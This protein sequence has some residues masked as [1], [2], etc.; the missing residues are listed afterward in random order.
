MNYL[1]TNQSFAKDNF[2]NISLNKEEICKDVFVYHSMIHNSELVYKALQETQNNEI[3][4]YLFSDWV[5][6]GTY[7]ITSY[8]NVSSFE[9]TVGSELLNI[10]YS[11]LEKNIDEHYAEIYKKLLVQFSLASI[12]TE[13]SQLVISDYISNVDFLLPQEMYFTRI[14]LCEYHINPLNEGDLLEMPYHTDY[15]AS[16]HFLSC[17]KF[18]VTC[19]TYFN[20]DY[21]GGEISFYIDGEIIDYKPKAGDMIVFPSGDPHFLNG[22]SYL[23]GVKKITKGKKNICRYYLKYKDNKYKDNLNDILNGNNKEKFQYYKLIREKYGS[24]KYEELLSHKNKL[25][26]NFDFEKYYQNNTF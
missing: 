10:M 24:V 20:D 21:D 22:K 23:H 2:L 19:N 14:D 1:K 16:D 25:I 4:S 13:T 8:F 7:G 18:L 15:V 5:Q 17:D 11:H 9:D 26:D 6:W 3:K 12:L